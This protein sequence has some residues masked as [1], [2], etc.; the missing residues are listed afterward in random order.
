MN[1]SSLE[2]HLAHINVGRLVAGAGDRRTAD[3]FAHLDRI[4]AIADA[5]PHRNDDQTSRATTTNWRTQR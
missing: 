5:S 1:D 4:N 2:W 3:F